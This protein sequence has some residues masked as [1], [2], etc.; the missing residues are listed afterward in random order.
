MSGKGVLK[1]VVF[2]AV[3]AASAGCATTGGD[4]GG[5]VPAPKF[6]S[7]SIDDN[8]VYIAKDKRFTVAVPFAAD[9]DNHRYM[10]VKEEYGPNEDYV[11]FGPGA[12][13]QRIY[14]IDFVTPPAGRSLPALDTVVSRMQGLVAQQAQQSYGTAPTV[15]GSQKTVIGGHD[16]YT[17]EMQQSVPS[18]HATLTHEVYMIYLGG[19]GVTVWVQTPSNNLSDQRALTPEQF[20]ESLKVTPPAGQ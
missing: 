7:G 5:L 6:L 10:K 19:S 8:N 13:D 9:T 15:G 20:A 14:R 11:S 17:W 4:I 18:M 1:G 3:F 12:V 2:G 16:A